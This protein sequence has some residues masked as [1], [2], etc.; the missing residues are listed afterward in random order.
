M[1]AMLRILKSTALCA[2]LIVVVMTCTS[3][4]LLAAHKVEGALPSDFNVEIAEP[5]MSC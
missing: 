5:K 1:L 4:P 3:L 2:V